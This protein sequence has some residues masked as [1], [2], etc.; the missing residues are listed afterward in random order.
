MDKRI[1]CFL[2]FI[3]I[4][5][6]SNAVEVVNFK[7]IS[8]EN[9]LMIQQILQK[10]N[11]EFFFS[12][13]L[14]LD[15]LKNCP[16]VIPIL[17]QWLY[18]EWHC[19]DIFLTK[20]KLIHSFITRLNNDRIP[21]TFVALKN[22]KPV[23]TIS[24]KKNIDPEFSDFPKNSVW[25]G[26]LQVVLEERNQGFGQELLKFAT[27]IAKYLGYE[28]LYFYTSNHMNVKWYLKKG[29]QII[30]ERPFR[31]HM[32]TIL[33]ISLKNVEKTDLSN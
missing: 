1:L 5:N 11:Q 22:D 9:D 27:T 23:G 19:Y 16:Q 30:E 2:S 15:L 32:I 29:A 12:H 14:R 28:K 10:K 25:M 18:E 8:M 31:N 33:H 26:S 4:A 7:E 21:I 13:S 3:L 24:L 6:F 20:E 17:A